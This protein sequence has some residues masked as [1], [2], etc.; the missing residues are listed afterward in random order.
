MFHATVVVFLLVGVFYSNSIRLSESAFSFFCARI[1]VGGSDFYRGSCVGIAW[2]TR[3]HAHSTVSL[4]RSRLQKAK[5]VRNTS[6]ST[7]CSFSIA[8]STKVRILS[9]E[10]NAPTRTHCIMYAMYGTYCNKNHDSD[11]KN[12]SSLHSSS[13]SFL[14]HTFPSKLTNFVDIS[15]KWWKIFWSYLY[16]STEW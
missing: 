9:D 15:L 7:I 4:H 16:P 1:W 5:S 13:I 14:K 8:L 3:V 11:S 10:I 6:I 12:P 2:S